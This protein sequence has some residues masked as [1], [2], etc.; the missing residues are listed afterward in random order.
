M[1][2]GASER[3]RA[4]A[5]LV[6][7]AIPSYN[8]ASTLAAT[9][10]SVLTQ[11]YTNVEVVVV[12]DGSIDSTQEVLRRYA[13]SVKVIRQENGGLASARNAGLLAASGKYIALLDAD[14]LCVPQRLSMQAEYMERHPDVVLCS[15]D[16]VGFDR[17]GPVSGS[18]IKKYYS[19]ILETPGGFA[20]IYAHREVLCLSGHLVPTY[21]GNVYEHMVLG[22]FIHPPTVLFRRGILETC[23]LLD[24]S[25]PNCCDYEW[26]I[27]VSRLGQIAYIDYPLLKYRF[28]EDQMSG[29]RHRVQLSLDIVHIMEKTLSTDPSLS[30]RV[31]H[32]FRRNYGRACL[33]AANELVD[34]HPLAGIRLLLRSASLGTIQP[35]TLLVLLK[36]G[37]PRRGLQWKRE[38]LAS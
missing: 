21:A 7:V 36:A 30:E 5:P 23:G 6:T 12:D 9:L 19:Q 1:R 29:R 27:R 11:T 16:F 4:L 24:K 17:N 35:R 33:D 25:I 3:S 22:S 38:R 32:R 14:D 18:C 15:T 20:G 37:I 8:A 26:F 2:G 28:S 10:E 31:R 13:G 34:A